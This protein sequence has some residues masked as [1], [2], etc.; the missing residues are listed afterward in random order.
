MTPWWRRR[1]GGA[2]AHRLSFVDRERISR[3]IAAGELGV[4]DRAGVGR[5]A[6]TV[7]R[8]TGVRGRAGIECAGRGGNAARQRGWRVPK[9]GKLCRVRRLLAAVEAGLEQCF[10]PQQYPRD[11]GFEHPD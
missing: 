10:S 2:F 3:G 9:P 6:S 11:C 5:S 8:E 4:C 1:P 7:C